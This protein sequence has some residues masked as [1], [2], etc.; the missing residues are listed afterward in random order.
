MHCFVE[1]ILQDIRSQRKKVVK[2][3][4]GNDNG[5]V[6]PGLIYSLSFIPVLEYFDYSILKTAISQSS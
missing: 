1:Q 2:E 6:I 4:Y 5:P 3:T